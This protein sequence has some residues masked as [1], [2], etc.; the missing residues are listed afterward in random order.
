VGVD[1]NIMSFLLKC[2]LALVGTLVA[3]GIVGACFRLLRWRL[4]ILAALWPCIVLAVIGP[5]DI[6][7]MS[8]SEGGAM[9]ILLVGFTVFYCV[10][11]VMGI[12]L[13]DFLRK[14]LTSKA[15]SRH[16]T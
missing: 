11:C 6:L 1:R 16:D 9:F 5:V 10:A 13:G 2:C 14:R 3:S 12:L 8:P 4:L 15:D 7:N